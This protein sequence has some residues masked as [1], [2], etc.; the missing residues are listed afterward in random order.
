MARKNQVPQ[1][2]RSPAPREDSPQ[3]SIHTPEQQGYG[4]AVERYSLHVGPLPSPEDL[5]KYDIICPGAANRILTLAEKQSAHR[6]E[7]ER[8][9]VQGG[10]A[11]ADRGQHYAFAIALACLLLAAFF[12]WLRF[13]WL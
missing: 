2:Q 1:Q 6:Q 11:R 8:T 4:V 13:P 7:L 12:G 3:A 10:S 5:G 9:V